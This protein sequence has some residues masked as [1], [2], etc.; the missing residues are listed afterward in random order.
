MYFPKFLAC[1]FC[2]E[3]KESYKNMHFLFLFFKMNNRK[4]LTGHFKQKILSIQ[5]LKNWPIYDFLKCVI[6]PL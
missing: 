4:I 1:L 6:Y 2:I 5:F 3:I